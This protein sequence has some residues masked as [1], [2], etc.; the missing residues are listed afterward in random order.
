MR[1]LLMDPSARWY[2]LADLCRDEGIDFILGHALYMKAVHGGK[3]KNDRQD[4]YTIAALVRGGTFPLAYA[5]PPAWHPIRDLVRRRNH[6]MALCNQTN[7]C[8]H[9]VRRP[10]EFPQLPLLSERSASNASATSIPSCVS[11]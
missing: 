2:W 5:Y 1:L 8:D 10:V 9:L 3:T 4:A 6:L 11:T 7:L